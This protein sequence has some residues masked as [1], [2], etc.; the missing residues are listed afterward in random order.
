MYA[1]RMP[2]PPTP[3]C[4]GCGYPLTGIPTDT[5]NFCVCPEC[6]LNQ[7]GASRGPESRSRT[8]AAGFVIGAC[9]AVPALLCAAVSGG[10]G[11]GDYFAACLLFP[12]SMLLTRV[13]G[14]E[15][16]VPLI[17]LAVVQYPAY[18]AAIGA[19]NAPGPR[20]WL[21]L[22]CVALAHIVA[23]LLCFCVLD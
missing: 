7:T 19:L 9:V 12:F 11:H 20:S 22:G 13:A 6:G 4:A 1:E 8:I 10:M 23:V 21:L 17:A 5:R 15:L 14:D 3:T 18:G 2:A 16:T